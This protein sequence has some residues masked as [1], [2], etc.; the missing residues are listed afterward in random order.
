[1]GARM[2]MGWMAGKT[3]AGD[4]NK[5]A[6]SASASAAGVIYTKNWNSCKAKHLQ[7]LPRAF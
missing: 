3:Q 5:A 7:L 4:K 6:A 1:M 2:A